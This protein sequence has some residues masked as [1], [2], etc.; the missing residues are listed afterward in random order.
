MIT[1]NT[2][3]TLTIVSFM[4]LVAAIV[5]AAYYVATWKKDI[6]TRLENVE[7][8]VEFEIEVRD[9]ADRE[10]RKELKETN[11]LLLEN[12]TSLVKIETDTTWIRAWLERMEDDG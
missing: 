5:V 8:A 7:K 1:K 12:K 2:K 3:I 9:Q 11:A 10:I 4:A 6:E